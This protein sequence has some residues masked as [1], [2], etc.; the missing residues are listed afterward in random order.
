[1]KK[2][3]LT[4]LGLAAVMMVLML[5]FGLTRGLDKLN[6]PKKASR[7]AFDVY[8]DEKNILIRLK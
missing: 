3:I 6:L 7:M 4:V 2:Q 8:G 1:M 5:P